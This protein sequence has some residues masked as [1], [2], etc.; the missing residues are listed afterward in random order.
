MAAA[1]AISLMI[2]AV[3]ESYERRPTVNLEVLSQVPQSK[4]LNQKRE[5]VSGRAAPGDVLIVYA[6]FGC[7]SCRRVLQ[8]IRRGKK[9]KQAFLFF[10][11]DPGGYGT[12]TALLFL[13]AE[14]ENQRRA[15]LDE[16]LDDES[17]S[18]QPIRDLRKRLDLGDAPSG[19]ARA[20]LRADI[21]LASELNIGLLPLVVQLNRDGPATVSIRE[22]TG[23]S[24]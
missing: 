16:I 18:V 14:T 21:A 15:I 9:T 24:W 12:E 3:L 7:G 1:V 20:A 8:A 22:I 4:L 11:E 13:D 17:R 10:A 5:I 23:Q 19:Q 6:D 2:L